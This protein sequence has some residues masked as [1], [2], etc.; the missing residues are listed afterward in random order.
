MKSSVD[1]ASQPTDWPTGR[2]SPAFEIW[3]WKMRRCVLNL[4]DCICVHAHLILMMI[5][6]TSLRSLNVFSALQFLCNTH[7]FWLRQ[8]LYLVYMRCRLQSQRHIHDTICRCDMSSLVCRLCVRV[9]FLFI[10]WFVALCRM[11]SLFWHEGVGFTTCTMH[12]IRFGVFI[13]CDYC[14]SKINVHMDVIA[15]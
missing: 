3:N 13:S 7:I 12:T 1:F 8:L 10:R 9:F 4:Y 14:V 11:S 5:A 15:W 2:P 6:L